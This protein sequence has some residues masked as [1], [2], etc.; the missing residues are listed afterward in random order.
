MPA[1]RRSWSVMSFLTKS[2]SRISFVEGI[3][4]ECMMNPL[5]RDMTLYV[6]KPYS[7]RVAGFRPNGALIQGYLANSDRR[8]PIRTCDIDEVIANDT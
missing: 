8:L 1:S 5:R 2:K 6:S 7:A 4:K 3:D